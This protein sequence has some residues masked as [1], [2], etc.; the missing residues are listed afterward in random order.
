MLLPLNWYEASFGGV[1][2]Q[3]YDTEPP[4]A[5]TACALTVTNDAS[6]I[7]SGIVNCVKRIGVARTSMERD[8]VTIPPSPS[9]MDRT[10]R[11]G[12]ATSGV[13]WIDAP[14]NDKVCPFCSVSV[15]L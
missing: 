8:A 11:T 1:I 3:R 10:T 6:L 2:V 14:A 15:Q 13:N 4:K 9:V 12:P 7:F 5:S